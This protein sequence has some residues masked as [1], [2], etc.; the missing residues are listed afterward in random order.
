V[1][2]RFLD[3]EAHAAFKEAVESIESRSAVEVVVAL[4]R[5]SAGYL[6]ANLIVG[7][8]VAFAGLAVMLFS[9]YPFGLIAILFDPFLVGALAGSLVELLPGVKRVLTPPGVRRRH[10]EHAARATFV[11]RGVHNTLDRSGVLVYISW[12]E[13]QVALV[14]DSGLVAT[15]TAEAL[16]AGEQTLTAAMSGGG[17][18]V[19]RELA[20]LADGFATAM[21]RRAGD[22]N[23]LPDAI[24]SD[25]VQR[26]KKP[27]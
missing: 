4:R 9:E 18:A 8:A 6:H 24:D 1:G 2:A 22:I 27:K 15:Y 14:A 7:L 23:E 5:R 17:V 13:Q 3:D 20:K 21:P 10:V 26:K 11:D 19:A 12:V 16:R 25:L